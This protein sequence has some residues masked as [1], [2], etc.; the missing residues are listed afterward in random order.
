MGVEDKIIWAG[1]MN[2]QEKRDAY[3]A[4]DVYVCPSIRESLGT[5]VIEAMAQGKPVI[6]TNTGGLPEVVPDKFCLYR[7]G[8]KE[9]LKKKIASIFSKS[10]LAQRLGK[11][12]R[13]KAE[14]YRFEKV[15][16]I[17]LKTLK[18]LF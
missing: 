14:N 15:K 9:E 8:D 17:Y 6:A 18:E 2:S 1:F 12:G 7:Q 4:C 11:D 5:S 13:K 3:A 10:S 16:T